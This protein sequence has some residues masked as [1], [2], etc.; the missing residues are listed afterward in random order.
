VDFL[1]FYLEQIVEEIIQKMKKKMR[2]RRRKMKI[3]WMMK[4]KM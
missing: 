2:R 4:M 1:I 3:V